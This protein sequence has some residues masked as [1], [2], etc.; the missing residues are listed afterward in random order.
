MIQIISISFQLAGALILLIWSFKAVTKQSVKNRCFAK[1]VSIERDESGNGFI[2]K[3]RLQNASREAILNMM[4]FCNLIIGY[5]ITF[6]ESNNYNRLCA[7]LITVFLTAIV[8]FLECLFS[9]IISYLRFPKDIK[10][11]SEEINELDVITNIIPSEIDELFK[12]SIAN[13]DSKS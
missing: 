11:T 2:E 4:A 3:K 9:W 6:W 10:L 5:G 8:L 12:E 1:G 7:I 13:K